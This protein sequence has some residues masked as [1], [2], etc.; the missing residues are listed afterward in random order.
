MFE[1]ET[2]NV[3]VSGA[4]TLL[5]IAGLVRF[6]AWLKSKDVKHQRTVAIASS[7]QQ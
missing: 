6:V 2:T 7:G 4:T 1:S 5:Y 3:L